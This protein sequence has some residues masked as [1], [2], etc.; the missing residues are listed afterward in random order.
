MHLAASALTGDVGKLIGEL[1]KGGCHVNDRDHLQR[2]PI[3]V[4]ALVGNGPALKK[5]CLL[6]AGTVM[7]MLSDT[8]NAAQH[9]TI[10]IPTGMDR[11]TAGSHCGHKSLRHSHDSPPAPPCPCSCVM[12]QT[13]RR[14]MC[15]AAVRYTWP[16]PTGTGSA[17]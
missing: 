2:T 12:W 17:S 16:W 8:D 15:R 10:N 9:N 14:W 1:H 11:V 6:D 5:L 7:A 4:A 13:P 3:H